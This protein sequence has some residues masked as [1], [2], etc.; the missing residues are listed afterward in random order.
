MKPGR[1]KNG[2]TLLENQLTRKPPSWMKRQQTAYSE[3]TE[4]LVR[5]ERSRTSYLQILNCQERVKRNLGGGW[6]AMA[7]PTG[8]RL[9]LAE[10]VVQRSI[11]RHGPKVED[12]SLVR[13]HSEYGG[14]ARTAPFPGLANA[15]PTTHGSASWAT[16]LRP[17]L[18]AYR[19]THTSRSCC[20][21]R[22]SSTLNTRGLM[23]SMSPVCGDWYSNVLTR[24]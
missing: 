4:L 8:G 1:T 11:M 5:I 10:L 20:W 24:R 12:S 16:F 9:Q 7:Q 6:T 18:C 21:S 2:K 15:P 17:P 23:A 3:D 14:Q 19:I 13:K 22:P